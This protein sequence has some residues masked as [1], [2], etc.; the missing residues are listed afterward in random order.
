MTLPDFAEEGIGLFWG[1]RFYWWHVLLTLARVPFGLFLCFEALLSPL[2][3]CHPFVCL[4]MV[5][6]RSLIRVRNRG[7]CLRKVTE[8]GILPS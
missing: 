3:I 6:G 2:S 5:V 8:M 7:S 4:K 1:V